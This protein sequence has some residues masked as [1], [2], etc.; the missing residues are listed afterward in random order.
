MPSARRSSLAAKHQRT[1][2]SVP[3]D[4]AGDHRL[5]LFQCGNSC[6][7]HEYGCAGGVELDPFGEIRDESRC[8]GFPV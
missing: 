1:K 5:A 2:L 3:L 4:G 7:L 8:H 6:A